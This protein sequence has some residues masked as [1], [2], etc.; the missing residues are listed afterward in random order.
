VEKFYSILTL[1]G[2]PD[3]LLEVNTTRDDAFNLRSFTS[4]ASRP[5]SDITYKVLINSNPLVGVTI[6]G[7]ANVDITPQPGTQAESDVSIEARDPEGNRVVSSFHVAV[8]QAR[9][10]R[11]EITVEPVVEVNQSRPV[12]ID[13]F[14][15]FGRAFAQ[16]V[17]LTLS[18]TLGSVDP[19][20]L[21]TS[22]A[23]ATATFLAG[24]TPGTAFLT[25]QSGAATKVVQIQIVA[26]Q[27]GVIAGHIFIDLNGN[28]VQD[29]NEANAVGIQVRITPA[30]S[31]Q[32]VVV[33]T[34]AYGNYRAEL[35]V[36][37]YVVE[38]LPAGALAL[39]TAG[40]FESTLAVSGASLPDVGLA[41]RLYMPRLRR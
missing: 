16:A 1:G 40:R 17:D 22:T 27:R 5:L 32:P 3:Q 15:Q 41:A 28:G 10:A 34:D 19:A 31:G 6:D 26:P 30:G 37:T 38:V 7:E 13:I 23:T 2:L 21:S 18:T 36:G 25:V 33:V 11:L 4:H 39:T 8:Q 29:A 35:L 9:A 14:D 20:A 24:G 12:K